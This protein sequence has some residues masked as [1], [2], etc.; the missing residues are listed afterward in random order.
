MP[1]VNAD[2]PPVQK[3]PDNP[4]S[5]CLYLQTEKKNNTNSPLPVLNMHQKDNILGYCFKSIFI[6]LHYSELTIFYLDKSS[7]AYKTSYKNVT[8]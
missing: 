1:P 2:Q 6:N 5:A 4:D 3:F 8:E 7:H